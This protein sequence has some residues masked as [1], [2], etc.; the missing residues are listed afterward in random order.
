MNST[1]AEV[2][3]MRRLFT[4]TLK[5]IYIYYKM[6]HFPNCSCVYFSH[7]NQ[8]RYF[9]TDNNKT[10]IEVFYVLENVISIDL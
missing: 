8:V 5:M 3:L 7:H 10:F 1:Q 6:Y 2:S 4:I 9:L